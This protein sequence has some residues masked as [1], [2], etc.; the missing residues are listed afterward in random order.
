MLTKAITVSSEQTFFATCLPHSAKKCDCFET[1]DLL[2]VQVRNIL[3]SKYEF[4]EL[5]TCSLVSVYTVE[6]ASENYKQGCNLG[7]G[8][9]AALGGRMRGG[10]K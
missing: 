1:R 3:L 5:G 8:G 10:G 6:E 4:L 9:A 7:G 2:Y